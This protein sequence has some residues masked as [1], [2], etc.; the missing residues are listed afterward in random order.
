[1]R[2]GTLIRLSLAGNRT[3]R[4]RAGL[5]AASAALAAVALLAAATV[6]AIHGGDFDYR[7][8]GRRVLAPG[9]GQYASALLVESGLRPGVIFA[10]V[11]LALP[12][13]ALAGQCIRLG[14]P[15]RDRR[16][17]ALRLGGATP[18]QTVVIAGAET[19][20]ASLLGSL[21][22][23]GVY[24]V[25]RVVLDRRDADGKLLLPTDVLPNPLILI[26]A[27]L[28]VP[29]LAGLIGLLLMRR[30]VITPLG[31][32]RRLRDRGPQPWPG[33]LIVLGLVLFA[34]KT[35]QN[36]LHLTPRH[37]RLPEWLPLA[38]MGAG[39]LCV[40]V[41]VVVG[42]GWISYTAGRLLRRYGRGPVSL[43]SGAR[44]MADP[45]NGSRTIGALLAAV[46]FGAGTLGFRADL[47]TDFAAQNRLGELTDPALGSAYDTGFY[48][49]AI[50]LVLVAVTIALVVAAGGVLV[51]LAEGIVARRRTY[52]A[53]TAGG[54]PRS[55][56]GAMLLVVTLV[57]LLPALL[58]AR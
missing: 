29:V 53:M 57:P 58:L 14:A 52:A 39:V 35:L 41:G 50:R 8:D 12:V 24:L 34:P 15:A 31:V 48:F 19:A 26:L 11:M 56:L 27:L 20:A 10:L 3:D 43:L 23:F 46:V 49:G 40:M 28:L 32:V 44:L 17:A 42:T 54:V 13:L 51:A 6:A 55:K 36:L 47:A 1:M 16:L 5:T 21:A 37:W 2:P 4:L 25:L 33:V 9:S 7:P 38:L 30:V 22:G 18:G 45:W